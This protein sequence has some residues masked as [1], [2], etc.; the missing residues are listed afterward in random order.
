MHRV[1][2]VAV[3]EVVDELYVA[4]KAG[5]RSAQTVGPKVADE[6][7][8][9][10]RAD[11]TGVVEEEGSAHV[12]LVVVEGAVVGDVASLPFLTEGSAEPQAGMVADEGTLAE[13]DPEGGVG[14]GAVDGTPFAVG[15]VGT[16]EA[17][18]DMEGAAVGVDG[19]TRRKTPDDSVCTIGI[20]LGVCYCNLTGVDR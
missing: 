3:E 13:G 4:A 7:A 20:K 1:A 6:G 8:V 15:G 14:T 16:E 17:V 10:Y 19:T 5:Y 9:E 12:G 2:E 11:A 18:D